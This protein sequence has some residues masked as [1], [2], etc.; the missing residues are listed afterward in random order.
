MTIPPVPVLFLL[1]LCIVAIVVLYDRRKH[2]H[3]CRPNI[4]R[5]SLK[6]A[7]HSYCLV[8]QLIILAIDHHHQLDALRLPRLYQTK[9]AIVYLY[10]P[11]SWMHYALGHGHG[12]RMSYNPPAAISHIVTRCPASSC[13]R[14]SATIQVSYAPS[15]LA[16]KFWDKR[17]Q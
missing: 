15:Q 16:A 9:A 1:L 14:S 5:P 10:Q 6:V 17:S 11:A 12:Y 3:A 13:P 7:V 8:C 2:L 4:R